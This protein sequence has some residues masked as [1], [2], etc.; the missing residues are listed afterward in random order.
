M[1][2]LIQSENYE[3]ACHTLAMRKRLSG[4][5]RQAD[6]EELEQWILKGQ[7]S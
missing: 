4:V 3:E 5:G 2:D 6:P 1:S 7:V